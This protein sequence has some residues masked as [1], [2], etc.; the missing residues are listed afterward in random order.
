VGRLVVAL[1]G[2]YPIYLTVGRL[3]DAAGEGATF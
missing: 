2:Y 1:R 3:P